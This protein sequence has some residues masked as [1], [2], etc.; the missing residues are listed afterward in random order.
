MIWLVRPRLHAVRHA[1]SSV[2]RGYHAAPGYVQFAM[3]LVTV[4]RSYHAVPGYMQ[5]I[6]DV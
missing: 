5:F 3:P 1:L 6:Q 4:P 2:P